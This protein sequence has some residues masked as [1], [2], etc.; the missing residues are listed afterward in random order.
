MRIALLVGAFFFV[1]G[2]ASEP[3]ATSSESLSSCSFIPGC[4]ELLEASDGPFSASIMTTGD[5]RR[6]LSVTYREAPSDALLLCR[7]FP[8]QPPLAFVFVTGPEEARIALRRSASVTCPTAFGDNPG[9]TDTAS[10]GLV[11]DEDP[12]AWETLFPRRPDGGRWFA[13]RVAAVNAH[14]TWDSRLG[15]DYRLV[16]APR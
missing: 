9:A 4:R 2:C 16:F 14:G 15:E 13:L 10:F 6:R 3:V 11:E 12:A 7:L 8:S 1:G 5:G